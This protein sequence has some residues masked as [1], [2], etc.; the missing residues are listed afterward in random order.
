MMILFPLVLP[1][2]MDITTIALPDFAIISAITFLAL[3]TGALLI[4]IFASQLR[5]VIK[6]GRSATMVNRSLASIL[7][8]AGGWMAF[9]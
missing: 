6:S 1:E 9:A 2:M 4:I 8:V 5:R 7:V 3:S